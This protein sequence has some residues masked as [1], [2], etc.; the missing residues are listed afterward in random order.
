M[1]RFHRGRQRKNPHAGSVAAKKQGRRRR[2]RGYAGGGIGGTH[3]GEG[4][5]QAAHKAAG[6]VCRR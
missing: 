5:G 3:G 6:G 4:G 1:P 2:D